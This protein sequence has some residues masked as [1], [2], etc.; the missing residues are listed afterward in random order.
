MNLVVF[1]HKRCWPSAHSPTGFATR[2]G[3]PIQMKAIS[4]LFDATTLVLPCTPVTTH[5]GEIPLVGHN[6]EVRPLSQ[7]HGHSLSR[8][9]RFPFWVLRNL[10]AMVKHARAA[11][12]I[13]TPIPGDIGTVGIFLAL[14]LRKPLFVR[15][16]GNWYKPITFAQRTWKKLMEVFA[17]GRN[18]MMAT[19]GGSAPPSP[20]NEN[21]TWIFSTSLT[22]RQLSAHRQQRAI[23]SPLRL[24]SV[25]RQEKQ[26]GVH[27]VIRS[28][29]ILLQDD[30]PIRLDIVGGGS[31]LPEFKALASE[32]NLCEY[33]HF[34]GAVTHDRV[35]ALLREAH[36]FCYPTMASEGFP[37]VVLE[38][39]A[40]G[41]PVITT[42]VSVL[43][44]LV[45]E[46]CGRIIPP[47]SPHAVAAA[48]RELISSPRA[49]KQASICAT[50]MASAYSLEA[51]KQELARRLEQSWGS[52]QKNGH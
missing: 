32:L 6:L 47:D 15:H 3:F 12:G 18:V 41:L 20:R 10:P 9:L 22:K 37:K 43:P 34:H 24:I 14:L 21:L 19:G 40:S 16:C 4:E 25:C 28:M 48:V 45:G 38:A 7:L 44:E 49:Y 30:R 31:A 50:E 29:P 36:L 35:M 11:D 27:T 52:L 13:H 42:D 8:K 26:K 33:V 39:L 23:S 17:G 5:E 2:G 51:W 46:A 1:S